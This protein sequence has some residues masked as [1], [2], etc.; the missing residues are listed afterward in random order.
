MV[1]RR[2]TLI[3]CFLF[4]S[5]I[6]AMATVV[7]EE[8]TLLPRMC[9]CVSN[10]QVQ[11]IWKNYTCL[12]HSILGSEFQLPFSLLALQYWAEKPKKRETGLL[13]PVDGLECLCFCC[14]FSMPINTTTKGVC[15]GLS[16]CSGNFVRSIL[17][18]LD[19]LP[20]IKFYYAFS[21]SMH[22]ARC[23]RTILYSEPIL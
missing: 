8:M 9:A 12:G 14:L 4:F 3:M 16:E 17:P 2:I 7:S 5:F 10:V 13:C 23:P 21:S 1:W 6:W 20:T 18:A 11:R 19:F 15:S 22:D